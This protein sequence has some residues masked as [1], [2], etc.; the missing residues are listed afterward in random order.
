LSLESGRKLGLTASL[1]EVILPVIGVISVIFLVFSLFVSL[2]SVSTEVLA[3]L[4]I[5]GFIAF[6]G[7]ILFIA[8][9]YSLSNY[10][11][12]PGIFKNVLF[13]FIINVV[14]AVIA[15]LI[16]MATI[17]T[18]IE[19]IFQGTT[20][21][22]PGFSATQFI[23]LFLAALAISFILEIVSAVFYM[24][25][26]NKLG[27]K[28]GIY[29]FKTAG[30]LYLIGTVLTIVGIGVL[31]LWI[32]WILAALGFYSLKPS[33]TSTFISSG[34]QTSLNGIAQKRFCPYC[35]IENTPDS[36]Y[37]VICGKKLQQT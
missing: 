25:A 27:E 33:S 12:E 3:F 26:F 18:S 6:A 4:V 32:A 17:L 14:G 36:V 23:T 15:L 34:A 5:A 7:F 13:G 1:I 31:L 28:S 11:I 22:T 29:N 19:K 30:L 24:R 9:M 10:Y 2:P 20:T 8:A 16:E 21:G 37:C 35:G